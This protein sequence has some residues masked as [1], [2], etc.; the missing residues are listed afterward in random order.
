MDIKQA[1]IALDTIIRKARIHLY[2][3]IQIAEILYHHR[4]LPGTIDLLN[5]E[6]YRNTSKKWRDDISRVL[7]GRPCTSSARFQDDL[8]NDNAIPPQ[9]L[10]I[11]GQ[12]NVR[13]NGAIEAYI[14]KH[15]T[16]KYTQLTNA[17]NYCL[18]ATKENFNVFHFINS[19]R[20][21]AGLKRS[22][23]KVYEIIVYALF[24]T[25]V[26][27][28]EFKI[29]IF[30][31][32]E[33]QDLLTEFSDFAKMI[34]C[35]DIDN[36][37]NIQN[38]QIFRVGITNA[39]D[40]GLDMYSNWGPAFQIKHLSLD[41]DLAHEIIDSIP[42]NKIIIVCKDA[43]EKCILSILNQIGWRNRIQSIVT[44]TNLIEWYEKALRG[45]YANLLGDDLLSCLCSEIPNEFPSLSEIPDILRKRKYDEIH[46]TFWKID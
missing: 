42:S 39:A 12:E 31:N 15:F 27:A 1:K 40:K 46:N 43:E 34:M 7:L 32:K 37:K 35:L 11:L 25:L 33:N 2:K 28:L 26:S 24:S 4:T 14:Y 16:N 3:P 17:L 23:D 36:D 5:L 38:A 18:N 22:I 8:F 13:T 10:N 29:E 30:F 41:V 21:E 9:V 20:N 44:E 6:D 45:K 19:F